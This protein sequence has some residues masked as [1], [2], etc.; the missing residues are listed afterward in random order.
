MAE[1]PLILTPLK[2]ALSTLE[3]A[4]SAPDSSFVRDS[5]VKR[6]EYTYEMSWKM[7]QR[8]LKHREDDIPPTRLELFVTLRDW[9]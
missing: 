9:D 4:L 6:F 3:E 5:I 8:Y 1:A 7:M 2:R